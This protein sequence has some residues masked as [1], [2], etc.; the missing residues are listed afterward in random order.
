MTCYINKNIVARVLQRTILRNYGENV[1]DM[2]GHYVE[3]LFRNQYKP[4]I[5]LMR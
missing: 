2:A 4:F 1:R 3:I 5:V